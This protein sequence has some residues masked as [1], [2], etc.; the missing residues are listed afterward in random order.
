MEKDILIKLKMDN[1]EE[2]VKFLKSLWSEKPQPR[3]LCDGKLDFFHV[4]GRAHKI[5][6]CRCFI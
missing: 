1:R 5:M 6:I 2:A 3:P 4:L